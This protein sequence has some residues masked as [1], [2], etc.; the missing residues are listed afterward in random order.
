MGTIQK[1]NAEAIGSVPR[2]RTCQSE[3]VVRDAFACF[4]RESGLWE[5]ENVFDD[6]HCHQCERATKLEWVSSDALQNTRIR[7]LNDR[8]R[9][10][11]QGNGMVLITSGIRDK[12]DVFVV[13]AVDAVR[14]FNAFSKDN[15]PWGEHD[16]GAVEI[17]G[18]KV[19]FKIDAYNPDCTAG[20]ENPANEALTH[21]VLT[22]MLASEY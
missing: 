13:Q 16:F 7:E 21:R 6:A 15:D 9:T 3:R 8:F 19:F 12:G 14:T 17:D 1:A 4:N 5:L 20:S 22:I 11:G 2:C 18:E 10:T